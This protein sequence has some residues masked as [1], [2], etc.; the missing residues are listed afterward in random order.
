MQNAIWTKYAANWR[1]K[2]ARS[3]NGKRAAIAKRFSG[4]AAPVLLFRP[5]DQVCRACACPRRAAPRL[6]QDKHTPCSHSPK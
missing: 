3:R 6:Y 1:Y 2:S 5:P 4:D